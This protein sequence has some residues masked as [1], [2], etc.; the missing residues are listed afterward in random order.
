[1]DYSMDNAARWWDAS[2]DA[3]FEHQDTDEEN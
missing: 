1:M 3:G 2:D